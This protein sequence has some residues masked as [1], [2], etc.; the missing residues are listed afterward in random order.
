MWNVMKQ[1]LPWRTVGAMAMG[2]GAACSD[3]PSA[4]RGDRSI[5]AHAAAPQRAM[6]EL[7]VFRA[8][9]AVRVNGE[10]RT[11]AA[12]TS[13][14]WAQ[15]GL[16]TAPVGQL[17]AGAA[18][19]AADALA[20][21]RVRAAARRT[22]APR[23]SKPTQV[24]LPDG[25]RAQ[26]VWRETPEGVPVELSIRIGEDEFRWRRTWDRRAGEYRL[27]SSIAEVVRGGHVVA[28]HT[29]DVDAAARQVGGASTP[30]IDLPLLTRWAKRFGSL[31][32]T[33][34]LPAALH[35]QEATSGMACAGASSALNASWLAWRVAVVGFSAALAYGSP[36]AILKT[37]GALLVA[38]AS[39]DAAEASYIDCFVAAAYAGVPLSNIA[40]P[41]E[42]DEA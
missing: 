3:S 9:Q 21:L 14:L 5:G 22:T 41:P 6:R 13:R 35:A 18:D 28:R 1:R 15:D 29:L 39:V 16:V 23:I 12:H 37:F 27:R 26:V 7:T 38:S 31:A 34:L 36:E 19:A 10:L 4:P 17:Q 8:Q 20:S 32:S 40:N 30:P 2:L 42:V 11:I 24:R 33:V 25:R